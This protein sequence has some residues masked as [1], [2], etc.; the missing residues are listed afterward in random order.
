[1]LSLKAQQP[2]IFDTKTKDPKSL[3]HIAIIMDGNGR[4]AQKQ[5]LP[6][7][8]GHEEGGKVARTIVQ[9]AIDHG[10]SYLT[11][12]AFSWENWQRPEAEV[13]ALMAL[14][15]RYIREEYLHFKKHGVK[16]NIIGNFSLLPEDVKEDI[17]RIHA[18]KIDM[19]TLTLTIALSYGG[20]EEITSA[21]KSIVRDVQ[22][23]GIDP[24]SI[25]QEMIEGY[26]YTSHIPDPDLVIRTGGQ[27][28]LSNF[29]PWQ[30]A[31]AELYFSD[32]LWPDFTS[33]EFYRAI[34]AFSKRERR[35][36][37]C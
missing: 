29:L 18:E 5:S 4:W 16:L 20:R 6:R 27:M 1:V 28:R 31:Y 12:Y 3:E 9:S 25:T 23:K 33:D 32:T 22:E 8:V 34:E 36:G 24:A 11:L 21:V 13:N 7:E 30:T 15:A 26:L 2:S 14:L 19:P 37:S 17:A 10:I 35:Y